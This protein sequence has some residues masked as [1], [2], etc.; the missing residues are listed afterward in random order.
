M[1]SVLHCFASVDIKLISLLISVLMSTSVGSQSICD[2]IIKEGRVRNVGLYQLI[3]RNES[4]SYRL[5]SREFEGDFQ[6]LTVEHPNLPPLRP[7]AYE[8]QLEIKGGNVTAHPFRFHEPHGLHKFYGGYGKGIDWLGKPEEAKVIRKET[9]F[10]CWLQ[11][12][13]DDDTVCLSEGKAI[14]C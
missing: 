11:R 8:H 2:F 7:M 14:L 10:N 13:E 3:H 1:F 6:N 12:K 9:H 4:I 5:F